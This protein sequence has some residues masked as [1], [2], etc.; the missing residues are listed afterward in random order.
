MDY[1]VIKTQ[2]NNGES[3]NI[4]EYIAASGVE[5]DSKCYKS[6]FFIFK[7]RCF[8]AYIKKVIPFSDN[9]KRG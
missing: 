5:K 8:V 6:F 4:S 7:A 1:K 3:I 9:W 2:P